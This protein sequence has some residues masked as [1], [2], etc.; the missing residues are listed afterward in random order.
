MSSE[1]SPRL[2]EERS[3]QPS[4]L[5]LPTG[6]AAFVG[7]TLRGPVDQPVRV[8]GFA[9]FQSLFGGLWQPSSLGYAIEQ[10]F[11]NGGREAIVVRVANG[12]RG[13]TVTLPTGDGRR[14]ELR[15][16]RPGTR[17]FLRV[18]IDYDNLPADDPA[19]FNLTVQRVRAQGS[20]HVEDQEIHRRLSIRAS[21]GPRFVTEA[22]ARSALVRVVG[23]PPASRPA[24]TIDADNGLA[25]GWIGSNADGDDG[26]PLT[27]YD[28]IGSEAERTGLFAL[29]DAES[30][31]LLYVPPLARDRDVGL[32]TWLVAERFCRRRRALLIVDP[33]QAWQTADDAIEGFDA[34]G[35]QSENATMFFPRVLAYDKLR[36]RFETFAPGGAVAGMLA[37]RDGRMPPWEEPEESLEPVLR[38]GYKPACLI[39]EA[40]RI[41]LRTHGV[42]ALLSLRPALRRGERPRTLAAGSVADF[43][44]LAPRRTHSY[45]LNCLVQ[46]TRWAATADSGAAAFATIDAQVREFLGDLYR[47]GAFRGRGPDDAYFVVCDESLNAAARGLTFL[48]GLAAARAGEFH[49]YRIVQTPAGGDAQPVTVNRWR[50]ARF[51][52]EQIEWVDRLAS[53]LEG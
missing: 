28:L 20:L 41:R 49:A 53:R 1:P 31:D 26:A 13:A 17:E 36:G 14:L 19:A 21:D 27:D 34:W 42:N 22:L 37:R 44:Y 18:C 48:V 39:T 43:R 51:T 29:D 9:Q 47:S 30:F 5:R 8:T 3:P 46:G 52:P 15:A 25:T 11:D 2:G 6:R 7:R 40:Q 10:F 45:I 24:R 16:V 33:P 4:I 12:A 50:D 32:A 23:G 35:F 38:P